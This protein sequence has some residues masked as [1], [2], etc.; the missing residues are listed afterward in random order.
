VV[1]SIS[2]NN[3]TALA[4]VS[5]LTVLTMVSRLIGF[6]REMAIAYSFGSALITDVFNMALSIPTILLSAISAGAATVL[7]PIYSRKKNNDGLEAATR[8]A[9]NVMGI[10]I[11]LFF[12]VSV[13]GAVFAGPVVRIFAP[14]FNDEQFSLTVEI[15]RFLFFTTAVNNVIMCITS[16]SQANQKFYGPALIGIPSSV[17][18][19]AMSLF[20]AE[21]L[22]IYALVYATAGSVAAQ[23]L[24]MVLYTA[25][26]FRFRPI[27]N[28]RDDVLP[29]VIR[30]SLPVML[31]VGVQEINFIVSR[32]LASGLPEGRIANMNFG[33]VLFGFPLGIV[34]VS[35]ITVVYPIFSKLA[36]QEKYAD[37]NRVL[38]RA[39]S[40]S[41]LAFFPITIIC[42]LFS[43]EI[44]QLAF[45]RGKFS[46][47]DTV[48]VALILVV[49]VPRYLFLCF[50][51]NMT[52]AFYALGNTKT[53]RNIALA[54]I[55]LN[56][57]LSFLLIHVFEVYGL[58]LAVTLAALLSGVLSV[59]TFRRRYG[60]IGSRRLIS[61]ITQYGLASACMLPVFWGFS[62]LWTPTV[63]ILPNVIFPEYWGIAPIWPSAPLLIRLTLPV[64]FGFA[65][66]AAILLAMRQREMIYVLNWVKGKLKSC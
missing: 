58:I 8:F 43:H 32:R 25:R 36:A 22:G 15:V 55:A 16:V 66:Y 5:V 12:T 57:A 2:N 56:I 62:F 50:T 3:Q 6:F 4:V 14:D 10:V 13:L 35:V 1:T 40:A 46:A 34:L 28:F 21:S 37:I 42:M 30:L 47:E 24:I 20:F 48:I 52:R 11:L 49:S 29:E 45:Q 38:L 9:N 64:A 53:P 18:F 17:I 39:I 60:S 54:S 65:V 59:I 61:D 63:A 31:S 44:T 26:F 41:L 23:L 51:D 19:I 7:I 33:N 27:L